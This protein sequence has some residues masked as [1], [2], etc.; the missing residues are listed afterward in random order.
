MLLLSREG[1][2]MRNTCS[3]I[4]ILCVLVVSLPNTSSGIGRT[5]P[6][7]F[8]TPSP[9]KFDGYGL[10]SLAQERRR[11][12]RFARELQRRLA[13]TSHILVYGRHQADLDAH[14]DRVRN[15]LVHKLGVNPYRV[16][17]EGQDCRRQFKVELWIVPPGAVRPTPNEAGILTP[18]K[19]KSRKSLAGVSGLTAAAHNKR[20]ERTAH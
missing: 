10:I 11:L 2:I 9:I 15:Y 4:V 13:V 17:T 14:S 18:C 6:P 16:I 19:V 8:D 7:L 12:D 3:V 1:V 20:L 5:K